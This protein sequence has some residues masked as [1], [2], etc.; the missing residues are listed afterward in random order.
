LDSS[1]LSRHRAR[2]LASAIL[3]LV[4][5]LA[6]TA[7]AARAAPATA[8]ASTGRQLEGDHL[9][10]ITVAAADVEVMR[11][12][13]ATLPFRLE[14]AHGRSHVRIAIRRAGGTTTRTIV[15]PGTVPAATD[16][17]LSFV[18][19]LAP[20]TYLW[21]VAAT[22]ARGHTAAARL[23]A[24]L[25]VDAVFPSS[26]AIARAIA[27]L[28]GRSGVTAVAVVDTA[29]VLH[30]WHQDDQFVTASVIKAMLLVEYLRT[31]A[32]VGSWA[33]ATLTP[34]IEFSDNN[35]AQSI[36]R[37]VGDRGLYAL[38]RAAG[39]KRFSIAG[40]LFGAQLT[41]ADQARFFYR[42]PGLVPAAHRAFALH[43]L[44]HVVSHQSWGIPAAAR[45]LGW[46]VWFKGGWRGTS[47]GQLVHQVARLHKGPR[48]FSMAV[49][50]N[51]DPSQGYGILTIR[52]VAAR[53]VA[54]T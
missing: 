10:F 8:T 46:Q 37:V 5:L 32:T 13:T 44:S 28:K 36:Y 12:A 29:G 34:M 45:P 22:D 19:H 54:G 7:A 24:R 26:A 11:G 17:K 35:A 31:H 42:L 33:R 23:S 21:T 15:V 50:T 43:L 47:I 1:H 49:F 4:A 41:A 27:W 51:G 14:G 25:T 18:C 40:Q 6:C 16:E 30:G 3:A 2:L 48:T 52:G 20:G 9:P 39:M 38:A 53:L